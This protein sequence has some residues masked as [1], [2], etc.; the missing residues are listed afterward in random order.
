M[1]TVLRY[2]PP[3]LS[4]G[5]GA[6]SLFTATT[7]PVAVER[8]GGLVMAKPTRSVSTRERATKGRPPKAASIVARAACPAVA[9]SPDNLVVECNEGFSELVGHDHPRGRNLQDLL[10]CRHPNGNRLSRGHIDLH[11]MALSGEAP[12]A[13]EIDIEPA[14]QPRTRVEVSVVVVFN[15]G[16]DDHTLVYLMRPRLRRRRTDAALDRLVASMETAAT[17][18]L[19]KAPLKNPPP[20]TDRQLQVLRLM[21]AGATA[22]EMAD[23]LGITPHTVRSHI[24]SIF[25]HLA[26]TRQTEA[27]ARAVRDGLI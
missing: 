12:A 13:F 26:V 19:E 18:P 6:V 4:E 27:V 23:D 1:N 14:G 8:P 24:R 22:A 3:V 5:T 25:E 11:E 21:A 20:L 2:P 16:D 10:R 7:K 15:N 17:A 9:T